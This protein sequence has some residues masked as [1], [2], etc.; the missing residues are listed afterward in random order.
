MAKS[1]KTRKTRLQTTSELA[2]EVANWM[3]GDRGPFGWND[4][5]NIQSELN[6]MSMQSHRRF[7][8]KLCAELRY[9]LDEVRRS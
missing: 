7:V 6:I 3:F 2:S 1:A 8:E 5:M 4:P 9:R